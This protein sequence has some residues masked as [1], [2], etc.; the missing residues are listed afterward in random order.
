MEVGRP[1][2]KGEG[3]RTLNKKPEGNRRDLGSAS[4]QGWALGLL[5]KRR[6]YL[7]NMVLRASGRL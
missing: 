5:W 1:A 6:G 2:V 4:V 7:E 3:L